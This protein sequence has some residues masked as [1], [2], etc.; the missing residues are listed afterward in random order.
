MT[1]MLGSIPQQDVF[2][3]VT[4]AKSAQIALWGSVLGASIYFCF[5]F[6]PMFI[7]Y[8]ATLIDPATYNEM[9]QKDHQRVL[10]T[11]V[12]QHTPVFAQVLF[13]GAVLSAIMSCSS[14]TLLAPSVAFSENVIRGFY[15]GMGDKP[16]C[17]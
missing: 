13:F 7:A 16:S 12:L 3:R 6:V 9:L 5:T 2:Q 15:P 11:L 4:S 14:A 10:P 17:A 1:M 8:S